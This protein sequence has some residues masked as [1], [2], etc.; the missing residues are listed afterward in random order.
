MPESFS[1]IPQRHQ[2]DCAV[3]CLAMLFGM[4]YEAVLMTFRHN[5]MAKGATFRQ[6]LTAAERLGHPLRIRR[7]FDLETA[8]GILCVQSDAWKT[9]HLVILKEGQVIDTD[10]T[11]WDV[12]V[13]L[14]A[15][16]ARPMSMLVEEPEERN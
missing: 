13:F 5:V 14:S 16:T 15:Y 7:R 11:L 8:T 1:I 4:S 3:A 10:A 6:V 9:D 12:D 2:M